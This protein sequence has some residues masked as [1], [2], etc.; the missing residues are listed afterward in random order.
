MSAE[1]MTEKQLR[2]LYY[3]YRCTICGRRYQDRKEADNC[4]RDCRRKYRERAEI[5]RR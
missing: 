3:G 1:G 5:K 4:Y 2:K